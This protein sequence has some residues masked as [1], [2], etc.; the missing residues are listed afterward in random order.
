[1][2]FN[3]TLQEVAKCLGLGWEDFATCIK[4]TSDPQRQLYKLTSIFRIDSP[5]YPVDISF[6][7]CWASLQLLKTKADGHSSQP[8]GTGVTHITA[9]GAVRLRLFIRQANR[10]REARHSV[11]SQRVLQVAITEVPGRLPADPWF[12]RKRN[13]FTVRGQALT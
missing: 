7:A 8:E 4:I 6:H 9:L 1:M 10:L 2:I 12:H 5:S 11:M 13:S 3:Y